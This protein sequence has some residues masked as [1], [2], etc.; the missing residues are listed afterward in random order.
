MSQAKPY[1]SMSQAKRNRAMHCHANERPPPA[2]LCS[3]VWSFQDLNGIRVQG[4]GVRGLELE[5]FVCGASKLFMVQECMLWS[6][7]P[8]R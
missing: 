1:Q 8:G 7:G 3:S 6:L 5:G 4:F 2:P